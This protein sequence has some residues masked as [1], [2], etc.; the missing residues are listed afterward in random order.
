MKNDGRALESL[1]ALVEGLH[2]PPDF[3]V[4]TNSRVFDE[5]GIQI[6]EFDVEI[7]GKVGT[8]EI[9]WLI[10]CRDRENK[11]A[12]GE[13][14]EQLVTRRDRFYFNK[15][16]AVSTGGF[17]PSA[18]NCAKRFGIELREVKNLSPQEFSNWFIANTVPLRV[19][20]ARLRGVRAIVDHGDI[21]ALEVA[22]KGRTIDQKIFR[23]TETGVFVSAFEIFRSQ[24]FS[25]QMGKLVQE[26][27]PSRGELSARLTVQFPDEKSHYV[28]EST[29]G[30]IRIREFVFA[31]AISVTESRLPVSRAQRYVGNEGDTISEMVSY[32]FPA[33][34]KQLSFEMHNIVQTGE[35]H[36]VV[37]VVKPKA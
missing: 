26:I 7:R 12:P 11:G 32:E 2:L 31:C 29:G 35:T 25:D 20:R 15:V 5:E 10:Q 1:V 21:P 33:W 9:A 17:S 6:A 22:I 27:D 37:R 30:V 8:G 14:I 34:D 16:T 4:K 3:S 24:L 23:S 36:V 18:V 28:V 19:P 13:W